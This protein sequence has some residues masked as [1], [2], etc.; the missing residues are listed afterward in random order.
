MTAPV[1]A[2]ELMRHGATVTN[3]LLEGLDSTRQAPPCV[4]VVIG[5]SGDLTSR[6]LFPAVARLAYQRQLPSAFA[7]VGVAGV[8]VRWLTKN[9][10]IGRVRW[11]RCRCYCR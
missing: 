6:K 3:P 11:F 2:Q 9:C 4:L 1:D 7:I 10:R 8:L 5:A